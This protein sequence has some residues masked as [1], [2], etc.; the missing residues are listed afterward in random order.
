[1]QM[2]AA[3]RSATS[4][5][6]DNRNSKHHSVQHAGINPSKCK[7]HYWLD[8]YMCM[9]MYMYALMECGQRM[10]LVIDS[11]NNDCCEYVFVEVVSMLV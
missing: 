7:S 5:N 1:M 4:A 11:Y 2:L 10:L 6:S 3:I 8:M 9:Y